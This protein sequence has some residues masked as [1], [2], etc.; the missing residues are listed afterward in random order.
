MNPK[1]FWRYV[2]SQIRVQQAVGGLLKHDGEQTVDD[3]DTANTLIRW[4]RSI[5]KTYVYLYIL[6]YV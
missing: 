5:S 1:R 3:I 4:A 2:A 6:H